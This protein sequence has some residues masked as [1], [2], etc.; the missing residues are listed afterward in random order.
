MPRRALNVER[1]DNVH[2]WPIRHMTV[3]RASF[4]LFGDKIISPL[5][6]LHGARL[7]LTRC[8]VSSCMNASSGY[9]VGANESDRSADAR[10]SIADLGTW[11]METFWA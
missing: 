6:C 2:G 5:S 4:R 10:D 1:G 9:P 8:G 11:V 3:K 7:K